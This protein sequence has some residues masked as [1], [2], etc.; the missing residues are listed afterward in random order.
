MRYRFYPLDQ[1]GEICGPYSAEV[2]EDDRAAV[3]WADEL[4]LRFGVEIWQGA[5]RVGRRLNASVAGQA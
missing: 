5:R 2:C 1:S 4:A 3:A